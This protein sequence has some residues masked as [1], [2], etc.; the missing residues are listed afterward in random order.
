MAAIIGSVLKDSFEG[1]NN[2]YQI[3]HFM[4]WTQLTKGESVGRNPCLTTPYPPVAPSLLS[5]L[6]CSLF[7]GPSFSSAF[8]PFSG[9]ANNRRKKQNR[10]S[11]RCWLH[12]FVPTVLPSLRAELSEKS[13]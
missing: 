5:Y 10:K 1:L 2:E 11:T 4:D 13:Q 6:I 7:L 8:N 9:E 3:Q 12:W